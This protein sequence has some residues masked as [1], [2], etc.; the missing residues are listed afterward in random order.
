MDGNN[1]SH[2]THLNISG[3]FWGLLLIIVGGLIIAANLGYVELNWGDVIKLWPL[4]IVAAG[5]SILA[6]KHIV[7]K[8]I[9]LILVFASL[10]LIVWALLG[11]LPTSY[12]NIQRSDIKISK[13]TAGISKAVVKVI[14]GAGNLVIDSD[15][16]SDIVRSVMNSNVAKVIYG[17]V[18]D[19]STETVTLTMDTP[20]SNNWFKFGSIKNDW[21]VTLNQL[22]P[23]SLHVD[24]GAVNSNIDISKTRVTS[25]VIN[26][27][28]SS[29][30]LKLG[31][32]E[33]E[34]SVDLK[35]GVSSIKIRVPESSGVAVN[36]ESGLGSDNLVD[37]TKISENVYETDNYDTS[38]NKINITAKTGVSS[39]TIIRY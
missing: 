3:L 23:I 38:S 33:K 34:L 11:G 35:S 5:A 20:K 10:A 27:G 15:N 21:N 26:L 17:D 7:W 8:I 2:H 39:L 6:V 25:A 1:Q 32:L 36:V 16:Q 18:V 19:G 12:G 24:A 31:S 29:L 13:Q 37:F 4:M 30:D 9:S 22:I 28:V 14:G